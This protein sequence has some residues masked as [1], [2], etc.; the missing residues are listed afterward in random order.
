[1]TAIR[2]TLPTRAALGVNCGRRVD[3]MLLDV[4][5]RGYR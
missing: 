4:D 5:M 3:P 2:E 1:V